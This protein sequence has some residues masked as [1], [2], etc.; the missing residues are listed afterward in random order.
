MQT[1]RERKKQETRTKIFSAAMN[2]FQERGFEA[3]TIDSIAEQ[4]DVARGTVFLHFPT[5]EAILA[6]WGQDS[7][8]EVIERRS[9]WDVPAYS[10]EQKIMKVF[11]IAMSTNREN[12]P[13][14]RVLVKSSLGTPS[15]MLQ[16]GDKLSLRN[17]F[18]DI[19]EV[20]QELRQLQESIDPII[21]GNMIENIYLHAVNDWV[22]A[23]GQW[24]IE[25]IFQ[26]KIH[27]LFNGL[28]Q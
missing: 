22:L 13:L 14:V 21:A 19:L 26:T 27:Y 11:E 9:E 23:E 20:G 7:L 2:L 15:A 17:L 3:T 8:E 16:S 1:R 10:C 24:P 25:E 18:G 6:H 28:N 5:K 4:A 12:L